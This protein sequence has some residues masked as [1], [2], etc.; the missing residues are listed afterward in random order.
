MSFIYDNVFEYDIPVINQ[1]PCIAEQIFFRDLNSHSNHRLPFQS[2]V[3]C[4][5]STWTLQCE[6]SHGLVFAW[7]CWFT[8]GPSGAAEGPAVG[9]AAAGGRS[10]GGHCT[11]P[12]TDPRCRTG[13]GGSGRRR[14]RSRGCAQRSCSGEQRPT[15]G[16][17]CHSPIRN[18][19][20]P[21]VVEDL[22]NHGV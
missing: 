7:C 2:S 3:N 14:G 11:G 19:R 13:S 18:L 22:E 20:V 10:S 5:T 21:T 16:P 9:P 6:C 12:G 17:S 8:T 15:P 4:H 1:M